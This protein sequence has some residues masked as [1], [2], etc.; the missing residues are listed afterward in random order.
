MRRTWC[1]QPLTNCSNGSNFDSGLEHRL[2][3]R[4]RL[5]LPL[6]LARQPL[7][8]AGKWL[9]SLDAEETARQ[10]AAGVAP[11]VTWALTIVQ[12]LPQWQ[13]AFSRDH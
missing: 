10:L 12:A 9:A 3:D 7:W 6:A 1:W 2:T 8:A 11:D 4:E 13:A 5:A